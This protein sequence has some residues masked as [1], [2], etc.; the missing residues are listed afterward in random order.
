MAYICEKPKGSCQ[1]CGHYRFDDDRQRMACFAQ[2]DES[3][4]A[5][6]GK[7]IY[8][9]DD[10]DAATAQVGDLVTFDVVDGFMNALPPASMRYDCSQ[11]GEPHERPGIRA[12]PGDVSDFP[13]TYLRSLGLLRTLFRRGKHRARGGDSLCIR[14]WSKSR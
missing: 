2:K 5:I 7:R 1:S 3:I 13:G 4:P 10:F 9:E 11:L 12:H 6:A 14:R 8:T